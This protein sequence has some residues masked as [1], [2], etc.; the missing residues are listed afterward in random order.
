VQAA[1]AWAAN[2]PFQ[3]TQQIASRFGGTRN[4]LVVHR[5]KGIAAKGGLRSQHRAKFVMGWK[6]GF[7]G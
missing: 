4:A 6:R 2:T 7:S 3:W 1:W 5:P